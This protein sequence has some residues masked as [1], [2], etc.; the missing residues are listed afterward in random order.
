[1]FILHACKENVISW[2]L[3]Q[4]LLLRDTHSIT[5][6]YTRAVTIMA[7]NF[8][9]L[10]YYALPIDYKYKVWYPE[11]KNMLSSKSAYP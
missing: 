11:E 3:D 7:D 6:T 4:G 5:A 2:L 9:L 8:I 1:M 10:T